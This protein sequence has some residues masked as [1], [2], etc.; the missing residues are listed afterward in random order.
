MGPGVCSI[1]GG[2]LFLDVSRCFLYDINDISMISYSFE[3]VR[4]RQRPLPCAV[5]TASPSVKN[6]QVEATFGWQW[7]YNMLQ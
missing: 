5:S 6:D 4:C 2:R 1:L 7:V 3:F